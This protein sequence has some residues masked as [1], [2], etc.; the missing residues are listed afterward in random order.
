MNAS[1][2]FECFVFALLVPLFLE[3]GILYRC[4]VGNLGQNCRHVY[5]AK[6]FD[7]DSLGGATKH[8]K[9]ANAFGGFGILLRSCSEPNTNADQID[10]LSQHPT[11]HHCYLTRLS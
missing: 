9:D 6:I 2:Y 8:V 10:G 11:H 3:G 5:L 1:K 7:V 4:T